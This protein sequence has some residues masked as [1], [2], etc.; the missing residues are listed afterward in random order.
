MAKDNFMLFGADIGN[1]K[2]SI[3][4]ANNNNNNIEII[5]GITRSSVGISKGEII[6]IEELSNSIAS[7]LN[8][9]LNKFDI[10]GYSISIN[11]IGTNIKSSNNI[12]R[13]GV[14]GE[15][16]REEDIKNAISASKIV[17]TAE[18]QEILHSISKKF[19]INDDESYTQ[20]NPIELKASILTAQTH[21]ILADSA[22]IK[23]LFNALEK[24]N[25]DISNIILDSIGAA[26]IILTQEE[27]EKGVCLIDFGA[28]TTKFLIFEDGEISYSNIFPIGCNEVT[29]DI[30]SAFETT[31]D[32]ASRLKTNYGSATI[33]N[34]NDDF[35]LNFKQV[36]N[37]EE[38]Y[39]SNKMLSEVIQKS[40]EKN[41]LSLIKNDLNANKINIDKLKSGFV[42][43]GGGSQIK[44]LEKLIKNFFSKRAKIGLMNKSI[45][46][47]SG[48][49]INDYRYTSAIGLLAFNDESFMEYM[50]KEKEKQK[51][52]YK[53]I[54]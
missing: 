43:L 27:K 24:K 33:D 41:I 31:I 44:G 19:I 30:S 4:A 8:D 1:D 20:L 35:L 2:I 34:L 7:L 17:K 39:L 23:E 38:R 21:I 45:V 6:S 9:M 52:W 42:L 46:S 22:I 26:E 48:L 28:E 5:G 10:E 50:E 12:G 18:N 16:I 49:F 25:I 37:S 15:L 3:V 29:E 36:N 51:K 32:E 11:Y 13:V 40:Y 54:L 53:K 47:E 14:K